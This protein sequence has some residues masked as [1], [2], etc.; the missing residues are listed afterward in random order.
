MRKL[1]LLILLLAVPALMRAQETKPYYLYSIVSYGGDLKYEECTV[2]IDNG[3]TIEKLRDEK[4]KSIVFA[5][6]AGAIM[7]FVSKGWELVSPG[8]TQQGLV[9]SGTGASESC[10][11]WVFR[12]PCPKE[13]FDK[14]VEDAVK[15]E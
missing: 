15:K 8:I 13:P 6:P 2:K 12:K 9:T 5:T 10:P 14:A 3:K 4:G 7:Y 11:Y 1:L